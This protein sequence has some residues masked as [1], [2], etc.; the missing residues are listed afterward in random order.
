[1]NRKAERLGVF[2]GT[3]NPVHHGHLILA[4]EAME[5]LKLDRLLMVPNYQ[6]PLRAGEVLVPAEARLEMLRAAVGG[7]PKMEVCDLEVKRGGPSYTVETLEALSKENPGAEVFF[8]CGADSLTT[9]DRWERI[10]RIVTLARVY[11]MTR[12]GTEAEGAHA[13]LLRRAPAVGSA[14]RLLSMTRMVDLSATEIRDRVAAGKSVRWMVPEAVDR[15][16]GER[17]YYR[18]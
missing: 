1:M 18:I 12:P 4:R 3:F 2:G 7:E 5:A 6:S 15:L 13:D 14:V 10:E 16:I 11:V 9:L 17:G 8:F